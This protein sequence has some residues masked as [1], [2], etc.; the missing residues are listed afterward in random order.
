M[1]AK[2][3]LPL[4]SFFLILL[5][6]KT[7]AQSLGDPVVSIT[8]GS[9]S[10][11]HSGA[12]PADSGSTSYT[13][14]SA[15]FPSDG[16]YTIENTT[17]GAG[18]VW[19]SATDHT[20]NTGGYMMVVNASVSKTDYF[21]KRAIT[22]LCSN[23]TYQFSAWVVN[24]LRSNDI[25]PPNITFA[26]EKTDG[27]IIQSFNTGTIARTNNNYQWVQESFNFTLPAGVGDVVIKMINNS[28]GGAP[29]NDLAIDDI[30][31]RP[32][33]PVIEASFSTSSSANTASACSDVP[34]T[35]T[36]NTTIPSGYTV[37]W[38]YKNGSGAWTDLTG[39]NSTSS[40]YQITSS[41][42][43]GTYYYRA[44]TAQAGN[45]NSALCRSASN[46]LTLTV[47]APPQSTATANTPVC[48]GTTL[49][50]SASTGVSYQWTGPNG[51][52][53]AIQSP[54]IDNVTAAAAGTYSVTVKSSSGCEVTA[55][56]PVVVN[57]QPV[58]A[59]DAVEPIC[60]GSSVTLN[61]SGG[62]TY[63][64]LPA[65]GLSDASIA[66]PVASPTDNT[67]YTVTVSNG[68][69]TSTA[70]VQVD[71]IKKPVA[72]A[73]P[74]RYIT[75]GQS[76]TLNG[77]TKGTNV[78]YY[79]TPTDNLSSSLELTPTASPMEDITYTLHVV[80]NS[81]CGD[82]ATDQVFVRV[83]KKVVIP[84]T[85]TPNG[86]GVND[87]WAIE[88]LNTYQT[89]TTQVFNRYGGLVF[90]STGYPEAWDGRSNGQD[91]PSGTYYYVIDLKNGNVMSGWVMVVR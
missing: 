62:S 80:S 91:I 84:N 89:S 47:G 28:A 11:T 8:F 34:Q 65:T 54:T 87:T 35:Y 60:E 12:L 79:W 17:A 10:S 14:S 53:S 25:S 56:V 88:A 7:N 75:Q 52:T 71:V 44:V 76:T 19:W 61:A 51:F 13:Y 42:V 82:E 38:Q 32:Y 50:L 67:L 43:A 30:V 58:A 15:N 46:V 29:A 4:I 57:A 23:T 24:L 45:I 48:A 74:D 49:T 59:V 70:T 2:K 1:E 22:G 18:N 33:G 9:G 72:N 36:L 26:I 73:G 21:Y 78:S 68:T 5:V 64:W 85:F 81:G 83:Y 37:L 90:K 40:S 66:N 20:G 3:L 16:S 27:T 69:C 41:S 55:T 63:S 39:A 86:D 77:S 6:R 31:F